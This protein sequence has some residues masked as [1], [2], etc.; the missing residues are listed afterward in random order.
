L[1]GGDQPLPTVIFWLPVWSRQ[2]RIAPFPWMP[3][4]ACADQC[5]DICTAHAETLATRFLL[6]ILVAP[7]P[8]RSFTTP[9]S[10]FVSIHPSQAFPQ[11]CRFRIHLGTRGRIALPLLWPRKLSQP[12]TLRPILTHFEI[13]VVPFT[14]NLNRLYI[15]MPFVAPSQIKQTIR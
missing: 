10:S 9:P 15:V 14:R 2:R 4:V 7:S 12:V 5:P 3:T 11:T 1:N 6:R 13:V 8:C